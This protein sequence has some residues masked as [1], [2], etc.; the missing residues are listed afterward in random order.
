MCTLSDSYP[1][2]LCNKE[3][4][5]CL[6][7]ITGTYYQRPVWGAAPQRW[8]HAVSR[9]LRPIA[10]KE[11][12]FTLLLCQRKWHVVYFTSCFSC[13]VVFSVCAPPPTQHITARRGTSPHARLVSAL[14]HLHFL[15][16]YRNDFVC[17]QGMRPL[18][19][20]RMMS[21]NYRESWGHYYILDLQR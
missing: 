4:K 13:A 1:W 21:F 18:T 14:H 3:T 11:T 5:T 19:S 10:K 9:Q 15:F 20:D 8:T 16:Y 12:S 2:M 17:Q 6:E 7:S